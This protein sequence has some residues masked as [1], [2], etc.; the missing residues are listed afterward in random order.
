MSETLSPPMQK[1]RQL[2]SSARSSGSLDPITVI[3]P[4]PVAGLF[5]RRTLA[6]SMGL[7]NVQFVG[8]ERVAELLGGPVLAEAGRR[9]LSRARRDRTMGK[10]LAADPG[11]FA[12]VA[13][14]ASTIEAVADAVS[15]LRTLSPAALGRFSARNLRCA[16][17]A[18]LAG[19]YS[20]ATRSWYESHDVLL[21]AIKAVSSP[22]G[23]AAGRTV[24]YCLGSLSALEQEFLRSLAVETI[25]HD[26]VDVASLSHVGAVS[27]ADAAGEVRAALGVVALAIESG[28]HLGSIAVL[29]SAATPW[30]RLLA[31]ELDGAGIP[32]S[33]RN[34]LTHAQSLAGRT[35]LGL[36][37]L[38]VGNFDRLDVA[39][40]LQGGAVRDPKSGVAVDGA[41]WAWHAQQAGV[42]RG[43]TSWTSRLADRAYS[44]ARRS[45][46]QSADVERF[47]EFMSGVARSA[48]LSGKQSA[49]GWATKFGALMADYVILPSD[50][51]GRVAVENAVTQLRLLDD[52]I[53]HGH[54]AVAIVRQQL[55]ASASRI[56]SF[57]EG[58][59]V[60]TV[61]EAVGVEFERVI[62]LGMVEGAF[63]RRSAGDG[64]LPAN[65][66]IELGL[67]FD[68]ATLA[69]REYAGIANLLAAA[70]S[71]TITFGRVD[72][73]AGRP[74]IP[75]PFVVDLV[76]AVG[77]GDLVSGLDLAHQ[78]RSD[79][80]CDVVASRVADLAHSRDATSV[81]DR[82]LRSVLGGGFFADTARSV[83]SHDAK[84]ST[85]FTEFDGLVGADGAADVIGDVMS[86][87]LLET[88]AA[89]PRRHFLE[90][91][92]G[93]KDSEPLQETEDLSALDHGSLVHDVLDELFR[94][95]PHPASHTE[96]WAQES[97][98]LV[99]ELVDSQIA[100]FRRR[101]RT[102]ERL[103]MA[104][105]RDDVI[106]IVRRL[107]H[108][109]DRRRAA[110][111]TVQ[112][113]SE[114][115]FG[116]DDIPEVAVPLSDGRIVR[117]R[118]KIDRIDLS[119]DGTRSLV[120]DYKTG[121][122]ESLGAVQTKM[123]NGS[124]L[125]LPLYAVA[126]RQLF[127]EAE[128]SARYWF[129]NDAAKYSTVDFPPS[130][131]GTD[132]L[133]HVVEEL[134]YGL[135]KGIFPAHPG[136]NA[137]NCSFC[138]VT[139]G[140]DPARIEQWDTKVGSSELARYVSLVTDTTDSED[141]ESGSPGGADGRS[142]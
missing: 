36:L 121:T 96:P 122:K 137:V 16:T 15:E 30:L 112:T 12:P 42:T 134:V 128:V 5:V 84:S 110:E 11:V 57:G 129:V 127:P 125:Q 79:D 142:E 80:R 46:E 1:L 60:G 65:E 3:V 29:S 6:R 123:K 17:L 103:P 133:G 93:L 141:D 120:V 107:L 89:C 67:T 86:A 61:A 76:N 32:S 73:R 82:R 124:R 24:A 18:E 113:H 26:P 77:G 34:S 139:A 49:A 111:Q 90:R 13:H 119:A 9:P 22:S 31:D 116:S 54:E 109:D 95:G 45:P 35:L 114:H 131:L 70:D 83:A 74:C 88:F 44:L 136:K 91:T 66:R 118:G 28:A 71:A 27:T 130:A 58:I 68:P 135:E 41:A 55:E 10:L 78:T 92:L 4:S 126:A 51:S 87:T 108:E 115:P 33:R 69:A 25:E 2:I 21:A 63:G 105:K 14:H 23:T 81:A 85:A 48:R 50:D 19:A 38:G 98:D 72:I 59:F 52:D 43:A 100:R 102:G 47:G 138:R 39:E 104:I 140:C 94:R 101:G 97:L 37:E 62:V 7:V 8:L 106:R 117:F 132:S 75:A 99:P 56:G 20:A 53:M 64:V 40:W